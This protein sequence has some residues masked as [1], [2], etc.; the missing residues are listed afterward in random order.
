MAISNWIAPSVIAYTGPKFGMVLGGIPYCLFMAVFFRP[1]LGTLYASSIL[2]GI[3][4]AVLWTSQGVFLTINSSDQTMSRNAGMFWAILQ[5]SNLWG[6]IFATVELSGQKSIDS[7]LRTR[8]FV[9]LLCAAILGVLLFLV[10]RYPGKRDRGRTATSRSTSTK[11]RCLHCTTKWREWVWLREIRQSFRLLMTLK[12]LLLAITFA[13][14]GFMLTFWSGVFGTSIHFTKVLGDERNYL[15]GLSG[16]VIGLGEITSG[17]LFGF[18]G[19]TIKRRGRSSIAVLGVVL[20]L[21][22][23]LLIF[24]FFPFDS[25]SHETDLATY[26]APNKDVAL[27]CSFLLGF[28]DA[29]IN[30]QIYALLGNTYSADSAPAFALFK[31]VQSVTAAIAFFYATMTLP[32]QLVIVTA[33][34]ILGAASFCIVELLNHREETKGLEIQ[35]QS[36]KK[37]TNL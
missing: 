26:V 14:T 3:G 7:A 30:V 22:S 2:L 11:V 36:P 28:G 27:I 24:L 25:P 1:Y 21:I 23:Y 8:L 35:L 29:A 4:A 13:Y 34:G 37:S 10:L 12:M 17:A 31:F 16:V 19:S 6:N 20:Q 32:G 15:L 33:T 5:L 9:G 18:L